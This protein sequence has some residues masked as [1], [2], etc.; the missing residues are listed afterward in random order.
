ML[1]VDWV[2][3]AGNSSFDPDLR[4]WE[5]LERSEWMTV[6]SY[7]PS[8]GVLSLTSG[9]SGLS[10]PTLSSSISACIFRAPPT[11]VW[12][13]RTPDA[14]PSPVWLNRTHTW[15]PM[16][17]A[18]FND[19]HPRVSLFPF[20]GGEI[21]EPCPSQSPF[22]YTFLDHLTPTLDF[23]LSCF[24]NTNRKVTRGHLNNFNSKRESNGE[25]KATFISLPV[26]TP[27]S[28]GESINRFLCKIPELSI[29]SH[30]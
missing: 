18:L 22:A 6:G 25:L 2:D 30:L 11:P 4:G 28:R 27:L 24:Q 19:L 23:N 10:T 9:F 21:M 8:A 14:S 7:A 5:A 1:R 20:Q 17:L 26:P 3:L 12:L 13:S 16:P 15:L 29:Y